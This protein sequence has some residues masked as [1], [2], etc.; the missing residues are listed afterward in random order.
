MTTQPDLFDTV[1]LVEEQPVGWGR[2]RPLE[3]VEP[4]EFVPW[5]TYVIS[6]E[7]AE[8]QLA[9]FLARSNTYRAYRCLM[10]R[11]AV[12]VDAAQW[13]AGAEQITKCPYARCSGWVQRDSE[14]IEPEVGPW[15]V[16]RVATPSVPTAAVVTSAE[17]ADVDP[18]TTLRWTPAATT[19][20]WAG[21]P[22][23]PPDPL[24][25]Y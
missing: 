6:P 12:V 9:R 5:G 22:P 17:P 11:C 19:A 21:E 15:N 13:T 10:C 4:Y 7:R 16:E 14:R 3:L 8:Q 23:E 1:A 25:D 2:E 20:G 24:Y 18:V